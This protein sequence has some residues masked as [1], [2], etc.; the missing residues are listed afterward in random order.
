MVEVPVRQLGKKTKQKRAIYEEVVKKIYSQK[1]R[2]LGM[3][4]GISE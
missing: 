3:T 4:I 2:S 1:S